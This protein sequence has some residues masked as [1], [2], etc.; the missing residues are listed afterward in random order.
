[1]LVIISLLLNTLLYYIL[2]AELQVTK[3]MLRLY[4]I[5]LLNMLDSSPNVHDRS[6]YAN[7]FSPHF[8]MQLGC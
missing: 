7:V 2:E 1:M 8:G 6:M 4:S 5:L 3:C